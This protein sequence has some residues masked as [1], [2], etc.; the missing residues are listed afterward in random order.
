MQVAVADF[1][2]IQSSLA[3][4]TW[5]DPDNILPEAIRR[6]APKRRKLTKH[7]AV[8]VALK[9]ICTTEDI[10]PPIEYFSGTFT[11]P[12][13][14]GVSCITYLGCYTGSFRYQK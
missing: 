6:S 7:V 9:L 1:E 8:C 13:R 2:T 4:P 11:H 12:V 5:V 10:N 14:S 3:E